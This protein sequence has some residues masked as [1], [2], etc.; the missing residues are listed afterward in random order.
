MTAS[1]MVVM[2][3]CSKKSHAKAQRRRER[4]KEIEWRKGRCA[5]A[6]CAEH[7]VR[8][9]V[10]A[11]ASASMIW[12][13]FRG[14]SQAFVVVQASSLLQAVQAGSL[15]HNGVTPSASG[16]FGCRSGI[17]AQSRRDF[18]N[19]ISRNRAARHQ[20]ATKH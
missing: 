11:L 7:A 19:K 17:L 6:K 3:F 5:K 14:F 16:V 2:V 13:R 8:S 1:A 18:L 4:C 20:P 15:H 10:S 9:L 12:I